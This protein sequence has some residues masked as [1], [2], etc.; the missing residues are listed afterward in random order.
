MEIDVSS[1]TGRSHFPISCQYEASIH[2]SVVTRPATVRNRRRSSYFLTAAKGPAFMRQGK[3]DEI[4][5]PNGHPGQFIRL[6][7]FIA[8]KEHRMKDTIRVYAFCRGDTGEKGTEGIA[9]MS[10]IPQINQTRTVPRKTINNQAGR[11]G[12]SGVDCDWLPV[13]KKEHCDR[14]RQEESLA[15]RG[16]SSRLIEQLSCRSPPGHMAAKMSLCK[17][18]P[19]PPVL[20]HLF[21]FHRHHP[22]PPLSLPIPCYYIKLALCSSAS[23]SFTVLLSTRFS[24]RDVLHHF[25]HPRRPFPGLW[26][27]CC[28][29][30]CSSR[31]CRRRDRIQP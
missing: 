31:Q 27:I 4:N 10:R 8:G 24:C 18:Y 6:F 5:L 30:R 20:L 7:A 11:C 16:A 14:K 21:L 3:L 1:E 2:V 29:S 23:R 22:R 28:H 25:F 17:A 15:T 26:R 13:R 9:C 12:V 19:M